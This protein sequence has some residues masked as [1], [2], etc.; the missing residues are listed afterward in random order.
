MKI[1]CN[2]PISTVKLPVSKLDV[3]IRPYTLKEEKILLLAKDAS[4]ATE[5]SSAMVQLVDNCTLDLLESSADLPLADLVYLFV[6]IRA[7]S[8]SEI[9]ELRFICKK[10]IEGSDIPCNGSISY[11]LNLNDLKVANLLESDSIMIDPSIGLGIRLNYVSVNSMNRAISQDDA[12]SQVKLIYDLMECLYDNELVETKQ[13]ITY[14]EFKDFIEDLPRNQL[15]II[16]DVINNN[17]VLS[18]T[19]KLVCSKCGNEVDY[20]LKGVN[21]FF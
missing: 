1:K 18:K 6:Q 13:D 3:K 2:L 15:K 14:A 7:K 4:D 8:T 20:E 5:Y 11:D 9:S 19:V 16:L 12:E 17:P 21:D 10:T